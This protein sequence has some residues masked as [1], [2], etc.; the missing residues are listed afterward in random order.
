MGR[1]TTILHAPAAALDHVAD[2]SQFC[3]LVHILRDLPADA[4]K[5]AQLITIPRQALSAAGLNKDGLKRAVARHDLAAIAPLIEDLGAR[6]KPL[7]PA[8]E[9]LLVDL[10]P[11]LGAAEH[12]ALDFLYRRYH[13][14]YAVIAR[15]YRAVLE[16]RLPG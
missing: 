7:I 1:T 12:A 9:R 4:R 15:D 6:A 8:S 11:W 10:A 14:T 3:Y 13:A 16:D 2:M 5:P